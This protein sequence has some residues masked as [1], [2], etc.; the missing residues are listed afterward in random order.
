MEKAD[1][2]AS[3]IYDTSDTVSQG[4][5]IKQNP[6]GGTEV[7]RGFS[8]TIIV[9]KGVGK[10]KVPS[11]S[12]VSKDMAEKLLNDVGLKLGNVSSD[13]DGS[14]GVGD[15]ISQ[16]IPSGSLVEKGTKVSITISLGEEETYHYEGVV[17]VLDSPLS[18]EESGTVEIVVE[19]NGKKKRSTARIML[20]R[21]RISHEY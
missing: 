17:S 9:S 4:Y 20:L 15:V 21:G 6:E 8:V 3:V 7:D 13:Y 18:G 1:L 11:L 5:V 12:G 2:K 14:V 16:D 19:Q 10:V